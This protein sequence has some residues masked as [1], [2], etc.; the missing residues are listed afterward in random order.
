MGLVAVCVRM[1]VSVIVVMTALL[2]GVAVL[3]FVIVDVFVRRFVRFAPC[4]DAHVRC[5][6]D[7]ARARGHAHAPHDRANA[8]GRVHDRGYVPIPLHDFYVRV[9]VRP[10]Y[11]LSL[12]F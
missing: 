8:Y 9:Y 2:V 5:G 11:S 4:D 3:L 7:R 1:V 12:V 10:P 6:H